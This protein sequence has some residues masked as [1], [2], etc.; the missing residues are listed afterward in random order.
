M[1]ELFDFKSRKRI[2]RIPVAE[3]QK[4]LTG[5]EKTDAAEKIRQ[6]SEHFR[7]CRDRSPISGKMETEIQKQ[8]A[9]LNDRGIEEL[10]RLALNSYEEL[11]DNN[12]SFYMALLRKINQK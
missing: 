7:K 5:D 4:E 9:I 2:D 3:D 11:W 6:L 12:P 1:V 10:Y 8:R